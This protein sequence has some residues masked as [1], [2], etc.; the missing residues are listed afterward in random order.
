MFGGGAWLGGWVIGV[1]GW[2]AGGC[3]GRMHGEGVLGAMVLTGGAAVAVGAGMPGLG[4]LGRVVMGFVA[5]WA[6][7]MAAYSAWQVSAH[8]WMSVPP[9]TVVMLMAS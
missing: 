7:A 5:G 9:T 6:R 2:V 4:G 8:M 1:A 3:G